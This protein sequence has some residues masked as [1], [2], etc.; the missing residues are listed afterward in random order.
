MTECNL[1]GG[2]RTQAGSIL[3]HVD[4]RYVTHSSALH[5]ETTCISTAR[6][7]MRGLDPLGLQ[8][9]SGRKIKIR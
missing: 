4:K 6:V 1:S 9:K 5:V 3:R 7:P 2:I 8:P